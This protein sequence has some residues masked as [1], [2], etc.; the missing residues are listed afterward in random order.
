M[1]LVSLETAK[2]HLRI[3]DVAS[4]DDLDRKIQQASAIVITHLKAQADD[5]WSDGTVDV[6]GNVEAATLIVLKNLRELE[7]IDW[8]T[9]DRLLIGLRDPA[10]A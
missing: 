3:T 2:E 1:G 10:L 9:V 7:A 6:P 8:V 4:D 5:G